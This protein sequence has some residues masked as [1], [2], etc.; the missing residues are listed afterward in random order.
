MHCAK[1][2]PT[3]SPN[4]NTVR[5]HRDVV[6]GPHAGFL[7][8]HHIDPLNLSPCGPFRHVRFLSS[9]GCACCSQAG[10]AMGAS[11]V[12]T[13]CISL[14]PACSCAMCTSLVPE[15]APRASC[16][17]RVRRFGPCV[18]YLDGFASRS[19]HV[20]RCSSARIHAAR[21]CLTFPTS[22]GTLPDCEERKWRH[23]RATVVD[24]ER[25]RTAMARMRPLHRWPSPSLRKRKT[26][27]VRTHALHS[28]LSLEC[29][30]R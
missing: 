2:P 29:K 22:H 4:A 10:C 15:W 9:C 19:G 3:H 26:C 8:Q 27:T 1:N 6:V 25:T 30:V 13:R 12:P 7:V 17:R 21:Q 20:R 5:L 11:P 23:A 16:R 14:A 24:A 28:P 18:G